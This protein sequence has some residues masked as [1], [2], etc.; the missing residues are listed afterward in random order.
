M[1]FFVGTTTDYR[2]EDRQE[3]GELRSGIGAIKRVLTPSSKKT[4][5]ITSKE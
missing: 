5:F 1:E 2:C 4:S 3:F